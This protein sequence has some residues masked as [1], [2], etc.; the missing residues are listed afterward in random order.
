MTTIIPEDFSLEIYSA[1]G[2]A[3]HLIETSSFFI[4]KR[5]HIKDLFKS[6]LINVFSFKY[7]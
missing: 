7:Y 4:R 2:S 5:K 6:L 3:K 1:G